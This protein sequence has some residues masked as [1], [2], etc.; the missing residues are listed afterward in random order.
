MLSWICIS[1]QKNQFTVFHL[2][3]PEILPIWSHQFLTMPTQKSFYQLLISMNLYRDAKNQPISSFCSRDIVDSKTLQSNWLTEFW[4]ISQEPD[5]Y[6]IENFSS[7]I[8]NYNNF[9]W[10]YW[11]KIPKFFNK[12]KKPLLLSHFW[13]IFSI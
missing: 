10:L 8:A 2:F 13:P 11:G 9:H 7:N 12:L 3:V 4:P 1:L 5:S 6:Q